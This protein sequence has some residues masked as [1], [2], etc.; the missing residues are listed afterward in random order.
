MNVVYAADEKFAEILTVS[1]ESLYDSNK[2][3][4]ELNVYVLDDGLADTSKGWLK[5]QA[6][7]YG[8]P[9]TF[10]GV[11][12]LDDYVGI[13]ISFQKKLSR[14]AFYRLF[15]TELLKNDIERILY[16]DC[17][18]VI[19]DSLAELENFEMSGF[20]AAADEPTAMKMK[21]KIE[22]SGTDSYYNSGVM[23]IDLKKWRENNVTERFVAYLKEKN[24]N[25]SFE[26]QGVLNHV[27]LNQIDRLPMRYNV[28]T[29][30]YAFGF[31]GF[32]M[33]K[34]DT[35]EYTE[36]E[37]QKACENPAIVHFT[38]CYVMARP[39]VRLNEHP[40]AHKWQESKEKTPWAATPAWSDTRGAGKKICAGIYKVLPGNLKYH[41]TYL[42]N[43]VLRPMLESLKG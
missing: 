26:D 7:K 4:T 1:L 12:A 32:C 40:F 5:Q 11:K 34:R 38:N 2:A 43:G 35:V 22:L 6:E 41:F 13:E 29:Q 9:L 24:G 16:L 8:R 18:T 42:V 31:N 37:A 14:A 33:T 30:W 23:L 20:C 39:W 3:L 17:D 15:C 19:L 10:V 36:N 27:F 21:K 25:V 28:T